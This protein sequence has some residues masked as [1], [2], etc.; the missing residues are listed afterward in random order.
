[1]KLHRVDKQGIRTFLKVTHWM[2]PTH[3]IIG[4]ISPIHTY[5]AKISLAMLAETRAASHLT[6]KLAVTRQQILSV[7][8][9][10]CNRSRIAPPAI[11][12][13]QHPPHQIG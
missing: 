9:R 10:R 8:T 2:R 11:S 4:E 6:S 12:Q 3:R 1:M 5:K 7:T 13:H